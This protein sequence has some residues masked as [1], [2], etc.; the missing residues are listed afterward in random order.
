MAPLYMELAVNTELSQM[1]VQYMRTVEPN[2]FIFCMGGSATWRAAMEVGQPVVRE[3]YA[4]RDYDDSG[5]IVFTRDAGRPDPAAIARKVVRA[6][7]DGKVKTV[8]GNDIDIDFESICFHSDTLG[9]LDIVRQMREALIAE[10]I[11][12]TSVSD[13][14]GH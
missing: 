2:A 4:D 13:V 10:G 9:A 14:A 11:R 5:S 12:I 3:F 6:C 7:K 1:F 8:K